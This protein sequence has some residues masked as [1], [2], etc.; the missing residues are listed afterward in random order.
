MTGFEP[1]GLDYS[2]E[3]IKD[4]YSTAVQLARQSVSDLRTRVEDITA[5]IDEY[6][7]LASSPKKEDRKQAA[8]TRSDLK[9]SKIG[10]WEATN[11]ENFLDHKPC[12]LGSEILAYAWLTTEKKYLAQSLGET[13]SWMRW[14]KQQQLS[15]GEIKRRVTALNS[16][17]VDMEKRFPAGIATFKA[18]NSVLGSEVVGNTLTTILATKDT[19]A[20]K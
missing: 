12:A 3:Q 14:E 17:I 1:Q 16:C 18:I 7:A 20:N 4:H 2:K 5:N 10:L 13:K 6:T 19:L 15:E 11:I 8:Q 9:W